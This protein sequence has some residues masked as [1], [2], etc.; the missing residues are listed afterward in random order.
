MKYSEEDLKRI[1]R[2]NYMKSWRK[3]NP[4]KVKKIEHDSLVRRGRKLLEE[5]ETIKND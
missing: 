3:R 2:N 5:K 4:E 1:A